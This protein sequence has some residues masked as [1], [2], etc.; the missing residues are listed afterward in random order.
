MKNPWEKHFERLWIF[1]EIQN[2][3]HKGVCQT[4]KMDKHGARVVWDKF[5]HKV[6]KS[7]SAV[8]MVTHV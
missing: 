1:M 4:D 5:S 2:G 3:R 6:H 7:G 8:R